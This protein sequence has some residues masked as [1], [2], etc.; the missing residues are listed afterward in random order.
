MRMKTLT[1]SPAPRVDRLRLLQSSWAGA[2]IAIVLLVL[3]LRVST[4]GFISMTNFAV[5]AD[6]IAT[7]AI[8]GLAQMLIIGAGGMNLSVGAIGGLVGVVT[9]GLMNELGLPPPLAILLGLIV[10]ALCGV[11]N[12]WAIIRLGL[13]G[14]TS[15]LVTLASGSVFTGVT[16]GITKSVPF[17]NLPEQFKWMGNFRWHGIPFMLFIMLIVA[18][19]VDFLFRRLGLGRQILALG[20]NLR[21]AELSGVPVQRVVILAHLLSGVLAG[22][23]AILLVSRLGSAHPDVGKDWMLGSFAGPIIG[24]TR[25]AGGKVSVTGA[26]LGAILLALIANGLVF[27]KIDVYWNTFIQG[28]IILAAVGLDRLRVLSTERA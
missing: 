4:R 21:A 2:L 28:M 18:V 15:F 5:I 22:T 3:F 23:A 16:L 10:G 19:L 20:G 26:I 8:V 9:G 13:S 14:V 24:G 27:L 1:L 11:F 6:I 25:L 7:T 12:G 17:Y